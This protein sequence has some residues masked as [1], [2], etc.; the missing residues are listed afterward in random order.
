L[1]NTQESVS[2]FRTDGQPGVTFSSAEVQ[3]ALLAALIEEDKREYRQDPSVDPGNPGL[4]HL[5]RV[6]E[7]DG[8][9]PKDDHD[10]EAMLIR[11]GLM[12]WDIPSALRNYYLHNFPIESEE[13]TMK[14]RFPWW[15]KINN[16]EQALFVRHFKILCL[17]G[18]YPSTELPFVRDVCIKILEAMVGGLGETEPSMDLVHAAEQRGYRRANIE[19]IINDT[20]HAFSTPMSTNQAAKYIDLPPRKTRRIIA[21][22][23]KING[24]VVKTGHGWQIPVVALDEW[25]LG[26]DKVKI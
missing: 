18:A 21:E 16:E 20:W 22:I 14:I 13:E 7:N 1:K 5:I 12:S 8:V 9:I 25:L 26:H 15:T 10:F 4:K 17:L 24:D 23:S 3:T 2:Q 11:K 6:V 19:V